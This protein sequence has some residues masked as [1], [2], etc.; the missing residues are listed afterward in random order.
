MTVP[1]L[2]LRLDKGSPLTSAEHDRN[3]QLLR[4]FCDGLAKLFEVVFNPDGSLK[5]N[6]IATGS[7]QDR[8]VT[9]PKLAWLANFFAVASGV[10]NYA[11]T[12]SPDAAFTY[13]DGA[14]GSFFC[15][16]KFT[17]ANTG[18]AD[19][20]VNSGGAKAIKK[21]TGD[22]LVAGDILAGSIHM[23]AYDGTNFQL[24]SASP[25]TAVV[26]GIPTFITPVVISTGTVAATWATYNTLAA[27]GVPV[28]ASAIIL[29]ADWAMHTP[30]G[31][32][33]PAVIGEI[34]MRSE[35][36]ANVY[37]VTRGSASGLGDGCAGV[38]QGIFPFKNAAGVLSFDY[39][40]LVGFD[41]GYNL[42]L[43]GYIS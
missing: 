10:D 14:A 34:N 9:Q 19:L 13:G 40:V 22:N 20:D 12:I 41:D 31:A 18:A 32:P 5:T 42:K 39:E 24:L 21:L 23:L 25:V 26:H 37:A 36:G 29:Q 7:I 1:P 30:D 43:I 2:T 8:A 11:A 35:S 3:L 15:I 38:N 4:D 17:N 27:D 16:V 33:G 28:T 6:S